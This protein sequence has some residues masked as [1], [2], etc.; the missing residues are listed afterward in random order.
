GGRVLARL[1][2]QMVAQNLSTRAAPGQ[3]CQKGRG[4]DDRMTGRNWGWR[5][6]FAPCPRRRTA[7]SPVG[8]RG[9]ALYLADVQRSARRYAV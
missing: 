9:G 6:G 3:L 2:V 8:F 1:L 5:R 7:A 4:P